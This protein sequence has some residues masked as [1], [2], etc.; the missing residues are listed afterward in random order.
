VSGPTQFKW[1]G[2]EQNDFSAKVLVTTHD[3]LGYL[4]EHFNLMTNGLRQGELLRNLLNLYVSPE[5]AR[6][7]ME[8]GALLGGQTALCTV[9]FSDIRGFTSLSE[10]MPPAELIEMLNQY[11]SVMIDATTHCGGFVN[12]FGG[13]SLLAVFGT[14]STPNR[15]TPPV[16]SVPRW[17]CARH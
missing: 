13:D 1:S 12:K 11:M 5:V 4:G 10:H 15:I 17:I 8:K 6:E 7:A 3:E 16:P 9:L 14:P 2:V